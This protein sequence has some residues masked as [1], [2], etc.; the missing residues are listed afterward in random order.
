MPPEIL[1]QIIETLN[2][3]HKDKVEFHNQNFDRLNKESKE[4]TKMLDN[5]YMDKLKGR[6]TE[7]EYDKYDQGFR[8]EIAVLES[9]LGMLQ[10]TDDSYYI[11]AKYALDL[12]S[13]AY[14]LFI[15]SEVEQKRQLLKL[16][17]Q[18]LMVE[19]KKVRIEAKKPFNFILDFVDGQRWLPEQDS[20][21]RPND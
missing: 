21:L 14:D 9:Q 1:H 11:T 13:R 15:S 12:S 19:G 5:L 20:N 2:T 18:N 8:E 10:E 17:L 6:I 16:I 4:I 7:N 3:V